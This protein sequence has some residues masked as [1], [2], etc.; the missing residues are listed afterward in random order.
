MLF[1][2]TCTGMFCGCVCG[3]RMGFFRASSTSSSG[4]RACHW[5]TGRLGLASMSD[6]WRR[7]TPEAP[8]PIQTFPMASLLPSLS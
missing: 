2:L 5:A 6:Q 1:V 7:P 4:H 8:K 3:C